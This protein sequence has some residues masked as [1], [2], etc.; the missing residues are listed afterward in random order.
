MSWKEIVVH[1][2][3]NRE[4]ASYLAIAA[5][6]ARRFRAR[7]TGIYPMPDLAMM[8]SA[9]ERIADEAAVR[10]YVREAYEK[11]ELLESRFRQCMSQPA[12]ECD[13][14]A[15]EGDPAQILMLAARS[16]DLVIVE[17]R[18]PETDESAWDLPE[19]VALNSGTPTLVVPHT[20]RYGEIG[21]RVLIAWNGSREAARAVSASIPLLDSADSV[22]L[23]S[24][25]SNEHFVTVTR[26]P[27]MSIRRRME[28]HC[29]KVESIEFRP[30]LGDEGPQIL[31]AAQ[32]H[33]CDVIVMGAY[34]HSRVREMVLGGATRDV[35]RLM[36][37]PILFAY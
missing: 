13:W 32:S 33:G 4:Q 24:G 3:S 1:A 22:V 31:A 15:G 2:K 18:N 37:T 10:Q 6:L 29:A 8:R 21:R 16:A 23:L 34:G 19:A 14:R 9:L 30:S 12:V 25:I 7:V 5:A 11:S 36:Q 20:G 27:Q 26:S 17:Q 28:S 35:L